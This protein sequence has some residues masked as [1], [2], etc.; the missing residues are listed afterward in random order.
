MGGDVRGVRGKGGGGDSSLR[1]ASSNSRTE[2]ANKE[3]QKKMW[4]TY[5]KESG[6]RESPPDF[7]YRHCM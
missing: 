5:E 6:L 3:R 2:G 4:E 7:Q 1:M